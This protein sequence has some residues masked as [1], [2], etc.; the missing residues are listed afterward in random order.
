[1]L[2][3]IRE[4]LG[5]NA[6]NKKISTLFVI[7]AGALWGIISIS[8]RFLSGE[9]FSSVEISFM[10]IASC[11]VM[12]FIFLIIFRRNLLIIRLKDL[13]MFI[14]TGVISLTL[15]SLCYFTTMINTQ[16]SIAVSLLYT[17]PA[18]IMIF[19]AALFKEKITPMK[20]VSIIMTVVGCALVSGFVGSAK[21]IGPKSLIIGIGAGFFYALYSIF[22]RYALRKYDTLTINFYTFLFSTLGFLPIVRADGLAHIA[23]A[24]QKVFIVAIAAAFVCGILPYLFYTAGLKNLD[25]SVAGILVAVEPLVGCLVGIFGWH[26][27][28]DV[29]KILGI[30]MILSSIVISSIKFKK[31][32][33]D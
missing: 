25:T 32:N 4:K 15:F 18:F 23:S 7:L 21:G 16:T 33:P 19:S 8:V 14:G 13:W 10:R 20:T 11:A 26:D 1:M 28:A 5:G 24:S 6:L 29:L 27:D 30:V 9:G 31:K 17:S 12:L 2:F 3:F 22:A